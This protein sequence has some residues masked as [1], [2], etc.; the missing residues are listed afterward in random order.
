MSKIRVNSSKISK[1][2][3]S[4]KLANGT[5]KVYEYYRAFILIRS[6]RFIKFF[7][8]DSEGYEK[9]KL[10]IKEIIEKSELATHTI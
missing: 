6:K 3:V 4:K 9:S 1:Y 2:L 8:Y 5:I 7:S 10:F